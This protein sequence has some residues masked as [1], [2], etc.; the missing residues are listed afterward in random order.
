MQKKLEQKRCNRL[1]VTIPQTGKQ[2]YESV[3]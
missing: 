2:I 3:H 1:G